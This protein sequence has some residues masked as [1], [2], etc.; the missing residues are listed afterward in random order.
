MRGEQG[1]REANGGG[2]GMKEAE[3]GGKRKIRIRK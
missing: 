1:H 2:E 3:A